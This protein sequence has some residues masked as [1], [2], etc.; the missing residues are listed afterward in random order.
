MPTRRAAFFRQAFKRGQSFFLEARLDFVSIPMPGF[1][2]REKALSP[3]TLLRLCRLFPLTVAPVP[4]CES[5]DPY[6][7]TKTNG[8]HRT[9]MGPAKVC[10]KAG[11]D[12]KTEH[13]TTAGD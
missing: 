7:N 11:C 3:F 9:R 2:P 5:S 12:D 10:R 1:N 8:K 13:S 6:H 4:A